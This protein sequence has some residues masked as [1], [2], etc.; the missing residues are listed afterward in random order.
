MKSTTRRTLATV[1]TGVTAALGAAA[2][3]AAANP[4]VPIPVPLEGASKA[5]GVELPRAGLQVPLV[6]PGVPQ[7]PRFVTGRMLPEHTL[8]Q[9]PINSALPGVNLQAPLPH[10]LD[11]RFD[12]VGIAAPA[13]D[14]RALGPGLNLEAPLTPPTP[15]NYGLPRLKMPEAGIAA[16]VLQTVADAE[17]GAGP[18]R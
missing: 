1:V 13:S 18:G 2:T 6:T 9:V 3:P 15:G 17:L 11:D 10:P 4:T 16:P 12:H 14:L 5:L 7:G 8:P